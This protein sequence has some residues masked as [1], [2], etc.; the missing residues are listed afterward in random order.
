MSFRVKKSGVWADT[1]TVSVKKS[2]AWATAG[3]VKVMKSGVWSIVWPVL[4]ASLTNQVVPAAGSSA[5]GAAAFYKVDN[6]GSVYRKLGLGAY[7]LLET[8]LDAGTNSNFEVRFTEIFSNGIG[9]TG[10]SALNTWLNLATDREVSV[11]GADIGDT[12]LRDFT[13]E[14]RETVTNT[15]LTSATITMSAERV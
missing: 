5:G 7:S 11:G 15:V 4:A 9:T 6:D 10:G 3:F 13:V 12:A 8:W 14:I 1:S 2:S